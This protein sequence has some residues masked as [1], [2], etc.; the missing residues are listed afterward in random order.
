MW[1]LY[2]VAQAAQT[3]VIPEGEMLHKRRTTEACQL[4]LSLQTLG[5]LELC[6]VKKYL[7]GSKNILMSLRI[8]SFII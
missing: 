6:T 1:V 3:L 4:Q 7:K 5:D 2:T 8:F